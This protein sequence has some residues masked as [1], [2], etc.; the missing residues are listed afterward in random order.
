MKSAQACTVRRKSDNYFFRT[1]HPL[2]EQ[3]A[4]SMPYHGP[5][6]ISAAVLWIAALT[7]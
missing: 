4:L 1:R 6:R 5:K 3:N 2:P 7:G